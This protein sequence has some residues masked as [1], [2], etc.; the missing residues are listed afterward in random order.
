MSPRPGPPYG[1]SA[2]TTGHIAPRADRRGINAHHQ[3]WTAS[4]A[5]TGT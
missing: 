2:Q 3:A 1:T 4:S 5:T